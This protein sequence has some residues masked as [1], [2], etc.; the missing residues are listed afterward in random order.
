M[1]LTGY[2]DVVRHPEAAIAP[3]DAAVLALAHATAE[4]GVAALFGITERLDGSTFRIAQVFAAGGEVRGIYRKRHLGEGEEMF[5]AG[6]EPVVFELGGR[7]FG[8]GICAE[9]HVDFPWDEPVAAGADVL[10]FPA[11]PGLNDR[12]ADEAGWRAGFE[13]WESCGLA[14]AIGH[15][16]RLRVHVAMAGQAGSTVDE[17]F[18]G[19]AALIDPNGDIVDRL[20][21]WRPGT[22][23]VDIP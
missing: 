8:V 7:K 5:T 14:E 4:T 21:D 19:I 9:G 20:P 13:W 22:L 1:S 18:P 6:T 3:D 11:A 15:A 10:F 23:V 17:D 16:R 12:C 2:V